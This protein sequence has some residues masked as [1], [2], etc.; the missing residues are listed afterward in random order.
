MDGY[1]SVTPV[2]DEEK[3]LLPALGVSMYF[4][5]LGV[6]AQRFDNWSNVFLN[7]TYLKRFIS[8]LVRKYF[9]ENVTATAL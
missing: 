3:R 7:E 6:Q 8:L 4:F 1:E 2:S 5:Y 9:E